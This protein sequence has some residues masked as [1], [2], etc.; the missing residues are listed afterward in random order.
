MKKIV[1]IVVAAMLGCSGII[2][3]EKQ[4]KRCT[5]V[6]RHNILLISVDDLSPQLVCYVKSHLPFQALRKYWDLDSKDEIKLAANPFPPENAPPESIHNWSETRYYS[7]VP[8]EGPM[9]D[10]E[11][12]KISIYPKRLCTRILLKHCQTC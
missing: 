3:S 8:D 7:N 11:A 5:P 12:L 9:P 10:T 1:Y 4:N 2:Q 6:E